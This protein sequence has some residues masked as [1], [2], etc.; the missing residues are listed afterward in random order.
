[1]SPR[2]GTLRRIA[3]T[4]CLMLLGST[5][6]SC[7]APSTPS[8]NADDTTAAVSFTDITGRTVA[9]DKQP[10]RIILGEG[11]SVFATGILNKEQPLDKVVAIGS[12]LKSNV[13]D[14]M[15]ELEKVNPEVKDLPEIGGFTKGDVAV[16]NL[17]SL[18]PDIILLSLDQY[19]ASEKTG[20]IEKM[21]ESNLTFA[22]T[23]F[24]AK[25]LENTTRS[26]DI[27]GEVFDHEKE[28]QDFNK[29]WQETVDLVKSRSAQ[30]AD[31]DKPTTFV[32]RAAALSDCCQS[33]NDSNISQL[34][35]VAAGTNI[36]DAVIDGES[37]A[38]TPEKVIEQDPNIIIATGGDWSEKRNKEGNPVGYAALGYRISETEAQ[39]SINKLYQE[40][41]G[42]DTLTAVKTGN[43]HGLWHQFYNSPF[44]YL[45]LLQIASW[46]HPEAYADIDV[47]TQWMQ[48]QE[49][50]SPVTGEGT[51][52][53][54]SIAPHEQ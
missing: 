20:L 16:E 9:L 12:D 22:V 26:M 50:Y 3:A 25:P 30:I 27:F 4:T 28:A 34:V 23:D 11:R 45:A 24:R 13:P 7:A 48:A 37:G 14:Y 40:Q 17:I 52:F 32:W 15:T 18:Q 47:N 19:Q 10:E 39:E 38:L 31:S 43:V 49:K 42:F 41:A 5:F 8:K 44:N 21:E 36:G 33:W 6:A 35:N 53:S 1:M 51:F 29:E 46:M 54:T 2:T